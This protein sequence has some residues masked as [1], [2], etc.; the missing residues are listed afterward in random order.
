MS[1]YDSN[2]SS[3]SFELDL[4]ALNAERRVQLAQQIDEYLERG[5]QLD[6]NR[7]QRFNQSLT[8]NQT[9]ER[10]RVNQAVRQLKSLYLNS[11][12]RDSLQ[13]RYRSFSQP[14]LSDTGSNGNKT[15]T[16]II[17]EKADYSFC[18]NHERPKS[19][20]G[21]RDSRESNSTLT[22]ERRRNSSGESSFSRDMFSY[23][24]N[25]FSKDYDRQIFDR[26]VQ[27]IKSSFPFYSPTIFKADPQ[28]IILKSQPSIRLLNFK[29]NKASFPPVSIL[30]S[31]KTAFQQCVPSSKDKFKRIELTLRFLG[32]KKRIGSHLNRE[33]SV[34]QQPH[35]TGLTQLRFRSQ[36]TPGKSFVIP[37]KP[38]ELNNFSLNLFIDG[39]R[40]FRLNACCA[41][42]HRPRSRIGH[43]QVIKIFGGLPCDSCVNLLSSFE[44]QLNTW[45]KNYRT[46]CKKSIEELE[47]DQILGP[48]EV[49]VVSFNFVDSKV[50]K[51][52]IY[53]IQQPPAS[54]SAPNL[55]DSKEDDKPHSLNEIEQTEHELKLGRDCE[56][57]KQGFGFF[58]KNR[59]HQEEPEEFDSYDSDV[60]EDKREN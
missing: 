3:S 43:F 42:R 8:D 1:F 2:F 55:T 46:D 21:R 27:P 53:N 28:V 58:N 26:S 33:I 48:S 15:L 37:L 20:Y 13:H 54:Q 12:S 23:Q 47:A 17:Q 7:V 30:K 51:S 35:K 14:N 44:K 56:D 50:T 49:D 39:V 32:L 59:L 29:H 9:L 45:K 11:L 22:I 34:F 18:L 19:S 36:I 60:D 6:P 25:A 5:H 57:L 4:F 38:Y 31:N 24:T 16:Q 40:D 52:D 41:Y 10:F